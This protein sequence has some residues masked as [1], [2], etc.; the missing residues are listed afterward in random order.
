MT[1]LEGRGELIDVTDDDRLRVIVNDDGS[2]DVYR[3]YRSTYFD[4]W[5]VDPEA[6]VSIG[7]IDELLRAIASQRK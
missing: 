5:H 3:E 7:N 6:G 1:Q 2:L 4:G